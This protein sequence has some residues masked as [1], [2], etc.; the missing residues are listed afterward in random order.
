[1]SQKFLA[2]YDF[3]YLSAKS[4]S[5][6]SVVTAIKEVIVLLILFKTV[7]LNLNL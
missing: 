5:S 7:R 6:N 3:I 2:F 4:Q 1:M